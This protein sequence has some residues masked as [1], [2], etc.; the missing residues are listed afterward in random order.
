MTYEKN[1]PQLGYK[2]DVVAQGSVLSSPK[3]ELRD[4]AGTLFKGSSPKKVW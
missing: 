3:N 2:L 1:Q 4:H